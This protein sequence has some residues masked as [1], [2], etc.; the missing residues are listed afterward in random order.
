[1]RMVNV[2]STIK[3]W[4]RKLRKQNMAFLAANA[5]NGTM[6]PIARDSATE[7]LGNVISGGM[8]F[9]GRTG[10]FHRRWNNRHQGTAHC[11]FFVGKIL[12]FH[13][14]VDSY[15]VRRL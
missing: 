14:V 10:F 5:R 8:L 12:I 13:L 11:P 2:R 9:A 1:M 7:D 4:F 3:S 6:F 15:A